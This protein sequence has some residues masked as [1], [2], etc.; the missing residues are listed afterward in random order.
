MISYRSL[1]FLIQ[2]RQVEIDVDYE[3]SSLAKELVEDVMF[4]S[5]TVMDLVGST[6]PCQELPS[7]M[8]VEPW[9]CVVFCG[10]REGKSKSSLFRLS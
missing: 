5:R 9:S 2:F 1:R 10:P 6:F 3:E 4:P 8:T 7:D